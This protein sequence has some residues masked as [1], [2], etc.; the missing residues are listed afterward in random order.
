MSVGI[1]YGLFPVWYETCHRLL[2]SQT[3]QY[4][5]SGPALPLKVTDQASI[6][7]DYESVV[8]VGKAKEDKPS[9]EI[10][11]NE[12]TAIAFKAVQMLEQGHTRQ[13]TYCKEN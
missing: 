3:Q 6:L 2:G 10:I 7:V 1:I 8:G 4:V 9:T 12:I 13:E 11:Q 5:Y